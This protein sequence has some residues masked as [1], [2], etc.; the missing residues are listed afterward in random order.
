MRHGGWSSEKCA[1]GYIEDSLCYYKRRTGDM[2]ANS[3][4]GTSASATSSDMIAGSLASKIG[5][6]S[7]T[8]G[9][10]SSM[11]ID[12]TSSIAMV[13][14]HARLKLF[15]TLTTVIQNWLNVT[16]RQNIFHVMIFRNNEMKEKWFSPK[17]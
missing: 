8:S 4:L 9:G 16:V 7:N 17:P 10:T 12:D 2:I 3:I 1:R 13:I 5:T 11:S 6:T 15:L 14:V